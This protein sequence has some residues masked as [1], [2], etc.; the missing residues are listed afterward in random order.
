MSRR[1]ASGFTL[2]EA[3]VALVIFSL[4]AV[5]LYG[6]LVTNIQA[7]DRVQASRDRGALMS[8]ALDVV[9]RV[10]P[11]EDASGGRDVG[12]LRIEWSARPVAPPRRGVTQIGVVTPFMVGLYDL[13][14]RVLRSG[15]E[16]DTFDVRQV[17]YRD[18]GGNPDDDI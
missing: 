7:I 9:R 5:A 13:H 16:V 12:D 1:R 6:W 4:G 3:I 17:G 15:Q 14:V 10:N 18:V 2:L 8:A 11:M